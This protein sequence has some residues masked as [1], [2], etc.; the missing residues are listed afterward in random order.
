MGIV[1]VLTLYLP[2]ACALALAGLAVLQR[3]RIRALRTRISDAARSDPLTGL[4]NRRSF[5][6]LLD[7]EVERARRTGRDIFDD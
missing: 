3:G 2:S 1:E 5:D 7:L 6:E 4:L